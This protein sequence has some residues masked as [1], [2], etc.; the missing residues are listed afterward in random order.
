VNTPPITVYQMLIDEL[1]EQRRAPNWK[2]ENDRETLA[3]LEDVYDL[4]DEKEREFV[5]ANGGCSWPDL[6]DMREEAP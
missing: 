5:E 1:R 3:L 4:L 6:Y 2:P